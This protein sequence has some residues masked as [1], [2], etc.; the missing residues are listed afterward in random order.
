MAGSLEA[1]DKVQ[2]VERTQA[3]GARKRDC[4]TEEEGQDL[5]CR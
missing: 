1:P 2:A 3:E 5:N 4:A